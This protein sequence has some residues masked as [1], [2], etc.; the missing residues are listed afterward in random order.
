MSRHACSPSR[1]HCCSGC[2][3]SE[4][5]FAPPSLLKIACVMALKATTTAL[6]SKNAGHLKYPARVARM[7]RLLVAATAQ[8]PSRF[9]ASRRSVSCASARRFVGVAP[10]TSPTVEVAK[11]QPMVVSAEENAMHNSYYLPYST[12]E[13]TAALPGQSHVDLSAF[14][15]TTF[16]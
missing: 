2:W 15:S 5:C 7:P 1:C 13:S 11:S 10:P 12:W 6:F 3:S 16:L 8:P 14:N 4:G 9:E